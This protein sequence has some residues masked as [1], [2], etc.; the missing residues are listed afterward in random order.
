[1]TK[2]LT[3]MKDV[4]LLMGLTIIAKMVIKKI[5]NSP[6]LSFIFFYIILNKVPVKGHLSQFLKTEIQ[7]IVHHIASISYDKFQISRMLLFIKEDSK[8]KIWILW[9]NSIRVEGSV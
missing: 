1:M 2:N 5:K 6:P 8:G 4:A 9:C 7:K 3:Y